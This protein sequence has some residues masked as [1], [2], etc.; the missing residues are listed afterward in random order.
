VVA[1]AAAVADVRTDSRAVRVPAADAAMVAR[2]AA[3]P[4]ASR[5]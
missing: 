1:S 4:A 5:A 2:V 3:S